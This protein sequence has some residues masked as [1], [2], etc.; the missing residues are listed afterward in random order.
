MT[1]PD[2]KI[3]ILGCGWYGLALAKKL[4]SLGYDVNGST[5]SAEKLS[6][7]EQS[8]VSP[9]LVNF[10]AE[11]ESFDPDFFNCDVLLISIPPKRNTAEQ[12]SFLAKIRRIANA[13]A[14]YLVPQI[15]FISS[16]SVYGEQ[17]QEV[18]ED[19]TPVPDTDSGKVILA[20][21][22]LL[23]KAENFTSTVIRFGGLI[24]PARDPARF[25]AGKKDI[26]NG[27]APVNLIHLSDCIGI[28]LSVIERK[29]YGHVYNACSPE[30]PSRAEFYTKATL[31]SNLEKP[32]FNDEL[33]HWKLVS[34]ITIPAQLDYQ[35]QYSINNLVLQENSSFL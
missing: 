19:I 32:H 20:S 27:R 30:H 9:F 31:A 4:V 1:K 33:Q 15:I 2:Q 34:S 23:H 29:A 13:A 7:L 11:Q 17:D 12:H 35:F 21:E 28:T 24:G 18:T 10:E 6:S 14:K 22:D 3:S 26:A 16:T 5:T 25:F 8:G